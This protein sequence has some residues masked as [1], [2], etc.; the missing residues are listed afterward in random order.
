MENLQPLVDDLWTSIEE[1]SEAI[2]EDEAQGS[3]SAGETPGADDEADAWAE[4][5]PGESYLSHRLT[6]EIAKRI[7]RYAGERNLRKVKEILPELAD[8]LQRYPG[9]VTEK[10][11]T[12]LLGVIDD[13]D[14]LEPVLMYERPAAST[15][16]D[17]P[18]LI[19]SVSN[20]LILTL[21]R[22]P[23]LLY[24]LSPRAFE[25]LM[26][27]V[28]AGFGYTV[29]L[30]AQTRDGG[31]D[32]IAVA[33][34]HGI[35]MRL[36]VECKRY[37]R[38]R[39]VDVGLVRQLYGVKQ[40]ERA[41]K[42]ILATTSYFSPEARRIE[43]QHIHELELKDYDAVERWIRTAALRKRLEASELESL[44]E[45]GNESGGVLPNG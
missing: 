13:L 31:K 5:L 33:S 9:Q 2:V 3:L 30:T 36:L 15:Q 27:E 12:L 42:A 34:L 6:L 19:V 26:A 28:F 25:E 45:L 8:H 1:V 38:E 11:E 14:I 7:H 44:S 23:E 10:V 4:E 20:E 18:P 35:E 24:Q 17:T 21:A 37:A 43:R 41:T 16:V 32:L 29:Q 40:M 22:Q 39:K